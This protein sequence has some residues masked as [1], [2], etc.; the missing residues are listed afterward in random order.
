[1]KFEHEKSSNW[2]RQAFQS[3]FTKLI[4]VILISGS[5]LVI[6]IFA[7]GQEGFKEFRGNF[8]SNN[9]AQ[10][11]MYLVRDLEENLNLEHALELSQRLF[12]IIRF[13]GENISWQTAPGIPPLEKVHFR[14]WTDKSADPFLLINKSN[15]DSFVNVRFG[16]Y[17]KQGVVTVDT[18]H[19]RFI[20]AEKHDDWREIS[21]FLP[22]IIAVLGLIGLILTGTWLALRWIMKPVS[23][24]SDG[25]SALG[26]GDLEFRLPE[27]RGDE[28]GNLAR[29]FN[30]MSESLREMLNA[31]EQLLLD[32]SHEL[33]S[34][35]TRMKVGLEFI[36]ANSYQESLQSD[37]QEMEQM[38]T[39]ILE[40]A[41]LKSEYGKIDLQPTDLVL[42]I[43][44]ACL[45]F[46]GKAPGIRFENYAEKCA[47]LVDVEQIQ[48]VLK[49]ILA[50]ALKYSAPESDPIKVRLSRD[51]SGIQLEIQDY[52][53][54]IPDEE[55]DLIFE[56]FYRV[57]KSRNKKTGGYGLGLSLCKTIIEAHGGT[58][59]VKSSMG[60]GAIFLLLLPNS[61]STI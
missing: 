44:K 33:R 1:M 23:W 42:L 58:I 39:E 36:T 46:E 27:K 26:E 43:E 2:L 29:A 41:R 53:Q 51:D 34:P 7:I 35:L 31:R 21:F 55:M 16:R 10:Y 49:N 37:V 47:A 13:E 60:Q 5:L 6:G 15:P 8:F 20:F 40:T 50:N 19:G 32:V 48:T 24:L 61:S 12:F 28:L 38:V 30:R 56:P 18:I 59:S 22:W 11:G 4:A 52:G 9:L 54:G 45:M 25:V 14:E 57:D 3:V 17:Q